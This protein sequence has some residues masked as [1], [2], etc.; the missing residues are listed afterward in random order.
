MLQVTFVVEQL[1]IDALSGDVRRFGLENVVMLALPLF[2]PDAIGATH[3][4][5]VVRADLTLK[6]DPVQIHI[7]IGHL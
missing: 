1:V 4:V 6:S 2:V 5:S 3:S 7:S